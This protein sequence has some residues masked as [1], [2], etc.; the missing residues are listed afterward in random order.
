MKGLD[1]F[2][3][4]FLEPMERSEPAEALPLEAAQARLFW[5]PVNFLDMD[6][7]EGP[8]FRATLDHRRGHRQ[9]N[10]TLVSF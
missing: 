3:F 9:S 4:M 5:D 1:R 2:S 7:A 8:L 10:P 6:K